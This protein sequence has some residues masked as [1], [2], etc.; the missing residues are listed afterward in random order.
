VIASLQL[1]ALAAEPGL[2]HAFSTLAAGEMARRRDGEPVATPAR[3]AF[4]AEHGFDAERL[5]TVGAVHGA[6]VQ[7]VDEPRGV[8]AGVD[9]LVT[10]RPD[11]P[12]L[13]TFADCCPVLLYDPAQCAVALCHAGWRGTAAV[14]RT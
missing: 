9:G 12:L 14:L 7:R 10:D 6:R 8:V 13:A 11:L 1:D 2:A 5:A 3:R 4:L